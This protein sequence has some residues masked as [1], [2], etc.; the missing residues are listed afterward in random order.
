MK[1]QTGSLL[2]AAFLAAFCLGVPAFAEQPAAPQ[3]DAAAAPAPAEALAEIS[4]A[5]EPQ[6]PVSEPDAAGETAEAQEQMTLVVLGDSIAAG[7]G[8]PDIQYGPAE[9]GLDMRP[10]FENYPADCYTSCLAQD[11]GL[12]RQH[13]INLGLPALMS[14]DMAELIRD[15]K[16]SQFNQPAGTFYDYPEYQDYLR[17]AD[18][19]VVQIGS[20]DALVPCIVALGNATNWKSEKAV[21]MLISGLYRDVADP[22]VRAQFFDALREISLTW[23]ETSD[24]F[25]LLF[26][27]MGQICR[28]AYDSAS[29]NLAQIVAELQALNPDAQIV[30]LGYTDPVPMIPCWSSYFNQMNRVEKQL[31]ADN[32]NVIYVPIPKTQTAPDG[33]PTVEGH[34]YIA[35][36]ILDALESDR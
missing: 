36:Q 31:A 2:L 27:E 29:V 23:Q 5:S 32:E 24:T 10:N 13:A 33:H 19:I 1:K 4:P 9:I 15:G 12:D 14:G 18:V 30:L 11:L 22:E 3:T 20:N 16:M 8:L 25:H 35:D 7:V 17:R 34:R 26:S 28:S 21:N 6:A